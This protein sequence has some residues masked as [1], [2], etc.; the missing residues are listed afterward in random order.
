M[1]WLWLAISIVSF[2]VA[3]RTHSMG[4]AALCMLAGLGCML[5]FILALA[6]MRIEGSGR[7]ASALMGPDE[8]RRMREI[9]ERKKREGSA[10]GAG[11]DNNAPTR[12]GS[13]D[14]SDGGV[15]HS[16][17]LD[18]GSDRGADHTR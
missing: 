4:L 8:V 3:F 17:A 7:D 5:M 9:I 15:D 12:A 1:R 18:R 2:A 13:V 6:A 14:P 16:V 11:A 10:A